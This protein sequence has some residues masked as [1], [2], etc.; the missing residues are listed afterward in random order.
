MVGP[1][2]PLLQTSFEVFIFLLIIPSSIIFNEKSLTRV[3]CSLAGDGVV[4]RGQAY[5]VRS[6]R[7]D[8]HDALAIY[9]AV[10]EA[11]QMAI[12]E[13]IPVLIEVISRFLCG[14]L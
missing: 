8:G 4:V 3:F 2:V 9:S 6:I 1:S 11:R 13:H 7:V 12:K 5:G 10:H 14:F